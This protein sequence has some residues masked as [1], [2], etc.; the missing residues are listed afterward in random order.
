STLLKMTGRCNDGVGA[1]VAAKGSVDQWAIAA[2]EN[3]PVLDPLGQ[4]PADGEAEENWWAKGVDNI[5]VAALWPVEL[6]GGKSKW[7]H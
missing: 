5:W 6:V 2:A 1:V 3:L 4:V 7:W